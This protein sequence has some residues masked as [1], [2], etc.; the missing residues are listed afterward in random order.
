MEEEHHTDQPAFDEAVY[1]KNRA[2]FLGF[3]RLSI[4]ILILIL[5]GAG[6]F[7]YQNKKAYTDQRARLDSEHKAIQEKHQKLNDDQTNTPR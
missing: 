2:R 5:L 6:Y 3:V 4:G 7:W 1:K